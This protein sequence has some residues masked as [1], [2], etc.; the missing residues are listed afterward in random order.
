MDTL[1]K[2][3]R[4]FLAG[5]AIFILIALFICIPVSLTWNYVMTYLFG[6]KTIS[7]GQAWCLSFLSG[8]L[9]KSTTTSK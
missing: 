1:L 6:F 8:V 4:V 5:T 9:F 2:V 3:L 7:W